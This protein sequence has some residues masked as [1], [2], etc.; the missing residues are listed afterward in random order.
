ML[1]PKSHEQTDT[2]RI[3]DMVSA[4]METGNTAKA[5]LVLAE[6]AD[7]FPIAVAYVRTS[8]LRE[9]GVRL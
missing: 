6:H 4:A 8:V 5:R 7:T 3:S 2:Q 1:T 9:Y